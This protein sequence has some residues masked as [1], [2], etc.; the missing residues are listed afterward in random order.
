MFHR[1]KIICLVYITFIATIISGQSINLGLGIEINQTRF[2]QKASSD[3]PIFSNPHKPGLG[4]SAHGN[5]N[6]IFKEK[7]LLAIKPSLSILNTKSEV[8]SSKK[9]E[10]VNLGIEI[11]Y[12]IKKL[13]L[14]CG[15]EYSYLNKLKSKYNNHTSDF[16]FFAN[17]RHYIHPIIIITYFLDKNWSAH[18]RFIYFRNDL[19]NSGA[20]D[21][22]GNLVGP[23]EVTP[24]TIA[25]GLNYNIQ[26]KK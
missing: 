20:L 24:Y 25:F 18:F 15:I 3:L 1:V 19:F 12:C 21:L 8:T 22:N 23:I 13:Q 6:V 7:F 17:N 5:F 11:G 16:T 10:Y 26:F 14:S 9:M 2:R 4:I